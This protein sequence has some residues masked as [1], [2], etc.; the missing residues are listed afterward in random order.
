MTYAITIDGTAGSGKSTLARN[1]HKKLNGFVLVDT[2]AFYRW[3]TYLCLRDKIDLTKETKVFKAVKEKLNLM[4]V[5]YPRGHKYYSAKV[6]FDGEE[7][8]KKIYTSE[9]DKHVS[10]VAQYWKV[11]NLVKKNVTNLAK[12]FN[13]II[14]GRDIG[15]EVLPK[16]EIKIYMN[17][18]IDARARRRYRDK[19]KQNKI[20]S[21]GETKTDMHHR[22]EMD[23]N[24]EHGPLR[25]P[26]DAFE[27]DNTFMTASQ[28]LDE[29]MKIIQK[30]EPAILKLEK[31]D[32]K[33][34]EAKKI[35]PDNYNTGSIFAS[36]RF[37]SNKTETT[38]TQT[39]KES[40]AEL[41]KRLKAKYKAQHS[42]DANLFN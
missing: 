5:P 34:K 16:A 40:L 41:K 30:N 2:G 21:Y 20:I 3:A 11:R 14:A 32:W 39:Q 26:D 7:I 37:E 23:K 42:D 38:T 17:P 12:E 27:I 13:I 8:N 9:I 29:V 6:M 15:T 22:D 4:F 36:N 18:S 10:I 33:K 35:E 31:I 19:V 28:C 1:L 24:R 25:K